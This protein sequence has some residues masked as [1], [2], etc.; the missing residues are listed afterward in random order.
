MGLASKMA[1]ANA[2][3][4]YP[5]QGGAPQGGAPQGG[6]GGYPGQQQYQA[7]PGQQG[8]APPGQ[9]SSSF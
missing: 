1:A 4:G 3:S 2:A 5:P 7:Y 8:A 6:Q 9:V